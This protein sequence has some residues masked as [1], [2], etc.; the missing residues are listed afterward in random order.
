MYA[1]RRSEDDLVDD[2]DELIQ[3]QG[4]LA[5]EKAAFQADKDGYVQEIRKLHDELKKKEA[6]AAEKQKSWLEASAN[7]NKELE[8]RRKAVRKLEAELSA[9]KQGEAQR[10]KDLEDL[11]SKYAASRAELQTKDG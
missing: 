3:A 1:L 8:R 5:E 6:E 4:R 10:V 7:V 11:T 2:H 9:Q